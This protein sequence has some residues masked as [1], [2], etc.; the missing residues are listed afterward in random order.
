MK[1]LHYGSIVIAIWDTL[2]STFEQAACELIAAGRSAVWPVAGYRDDR[3]EVSIQLAIGPGIAFAI[4]DTWLPDEREPAQHDLDSIAYIRDERESVEKEQQHAEV[5]NVLVYGRWDRRSSRSAGVWQFSGHP[6]VSTARTPQEAVAS[7]NH[8]TI[9]VV[10]ISE[11]GA[12]GDSAWS[13]LYIVGRQFG[14]PDD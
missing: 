2:A 5:R 13:N 8:A 10:S 11:S 14:E 4:T 6:S 12:P 3:D 9:E 1:H 7:L